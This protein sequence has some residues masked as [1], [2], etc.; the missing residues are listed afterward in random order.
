MEF[1]ASELIGVCIAGLILIFFRQY[2]SPSVM[3]II[4]SFI[5]VAA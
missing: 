4:E 1:K 3:L 5:L 2:I